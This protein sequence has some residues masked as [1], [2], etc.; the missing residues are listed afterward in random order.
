MSKKSERITNPEPFTPFESDEL[1]PCSKIQGQLGEYEGEIEEEV[2]LLEKALFSEE[3][4][5]EKIKDVQVSSGVQSVPKLDTSKVYNGHVTEPEKWSPSAMYRATKIFASNMDVKKAKRFFK[6]VLLPCS[7]TCTMRDAVIL[8]SIIECFSIPPQL[9]SAALF[10]LAMM[11]YYCSTS[12]FIKLLIEK[13]YVLPYRILDALVAHFM[14]F[15]ADSRVM[16][17][18]WHLSLLAFAQREP[19]IDHIKVAY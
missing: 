4:I 6:H 5:V 2:K 12:I 3:I 15:Y 9:S 16:P 14:K 19:H 17:V 10:K 13:K 8:G 11:D 7:R 1:I 18:I